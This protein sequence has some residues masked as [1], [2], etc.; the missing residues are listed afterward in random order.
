[1]GSE[2]AM[3]IS[4]YLGMLILWLIL[5]P[6][7]IVGICMAVFEKKN[8]NKLIGRFTIIWGLIALGLLTMHLQIE[9]IYGSE[10]LE[11]L[12]KSE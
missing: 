7:V 5:Y 11:S 12:S 10:I 4:H 8:Q 3:A 1:M 9:V 6:L 2:T